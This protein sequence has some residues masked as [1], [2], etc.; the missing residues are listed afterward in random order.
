MLANV[1]HIQLESIEETSR[2][3]VPVA[4]T[5]PGISVCPSLIVMMR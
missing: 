2:L 4:K 3:T 1:R 5:S